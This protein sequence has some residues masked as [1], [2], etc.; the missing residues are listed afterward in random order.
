MTSTFTLRS[1]DEP[2]HSFAFTK[3]RQQL[4]GAIPG[5]CSSDDK[6]DGGT[7][8]E[9]YGEAWREQRL[10]LT[11]AQVEAQLS[12]RLAGAFARRPPADKPV[13][14]TGIGSV[15][16]VVGGIPF[17]G[18]TEIAGSRWC[19]AGRATL[20]VQ[21]LRQAS[22]EFC[23]GLVDAT[24]SFDPRS[25]EAAGVYLR[26]LLWIRSGG[27]DMKALERAFKSAD[28]LLQGSG[29]F[30][31]LI[32]DLGGISEKFV[33]RVPLSTWFRFRA[34]VEKLSAPVVFIT[35]QPVLGTCSCL[36]LLLSG[37]QLQ[38]SQPS[39]ESPTHARLPGTIDFQVQVAARRSF[40]KPSQAI[41]SF[42][43]QRQWA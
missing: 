3:S 35:P 42:S 43:A 37:G 5:G 7:P 19:S 22:R 23:C 25:A 10:H 39:G 24:D 31:L 36:T 11:R 1:L 40:K 33:R 32:V 13:L 30:G 14:P 9:C 17:G 26:H 27:R 34:V 16:G 41:R 18:I 20:L 12:D 6:T 15:D 8:R 29:G 21:L 2:E 38:W 4:D 28:L